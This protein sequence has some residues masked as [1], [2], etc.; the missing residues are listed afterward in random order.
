[1]NQNKRLW[2]KAKKTILRGNSL[3]SKNPEN[4][5]KNWPAYFDRAKGCYIWSIDKKK[6][7]DFSYMGI[8]TNIL[9]Y[10]NSKIDNHINLP[11]HRKEKPHPQTYKLQPST[12]FPLVSI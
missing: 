8:G 10:S 11:R 3:F 7:T 1:M 9:G 4:Y 6:Y 12:T 2:K 5:S